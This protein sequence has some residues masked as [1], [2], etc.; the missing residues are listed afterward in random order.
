MTVIKR[1][2]SPFLDEKYG[3]IKNIYTLPTYYGLPRVYVKMAFGGNY[4]TA[5]FNASE[6]VL[7]NL[8]QII[9]QLENTL[10]VIL[11]YIQTRKF[12]LTMKKR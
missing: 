6:Q 4:S 12:R 8:K 9:R 10:S 11:V 5:G 1:Q 7:Q 3:L 2:K